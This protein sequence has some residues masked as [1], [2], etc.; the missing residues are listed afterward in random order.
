[1]KNDIDC[2]VIC[3]PDFPLPVPEL[4]RNEYDFL[5]HRSKTEGWKKLR[6]MFG[7]AWANDI[8]EWDWIEEDL[9]PEE[10]RDR[11]AFAEAKTRGK[12][13][14]DDL[15]V[16][17][18]EHDVRYLFCHESDIHLEGRKRNPF[19]RDEVRRFRSMG[20]KVTEKDKTPNK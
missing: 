7:F 10:V 11:V 16:T 13:G 19:L 2:E 8:Y 5:I 1:M 6:L 18:L 14:S 20:W 15:F 17:I 12:V 4:I 9:G 3:R